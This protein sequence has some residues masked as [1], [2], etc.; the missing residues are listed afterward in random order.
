MD[1]LLRKRKSHAP[2]LERVGRTLEKMEDSEHVEAEDVIT[3][4]DNLNSIWSSYLAVHQTILDLAED[5]AAYEEVIRHQIAF[6]EEYLSLKKGLGKLQ[7]RIESTEHEVTINQQN[8]GNTSVIETLMQQQAQFLRA[9]ASNAGASTSSIPPT[10]NEVQNDIPSLPNLRLPRMNLP[11]FSG[12]FLEWQ[13]F[14]DLFSGS[15]HQNPSLRPSQ[16]LYFLKTHLA[17]EAA[18]LISHLNV[19]D[20]NYQPAL[21]KLRERYNKPREIANLHITRFLSQPH[22][23]ASSPSGLRS[24]HDVSDEVIRALAALEREGR[25]IWLMHIIYEKLDA[26]TKELWC[27]KIVEL[28]EDAVNFDA[29]LRFIDNRSSALQSSQRSRI[30]S[31]APNNKPQVSKPQPPAVPMRQK[32]CQNCLRHHSGE[33]CKAGSCRKCGLMHHTLL[34]KAFQPAAQFTSTEAPV[35]TPPQALISAINLADHLDG[36]SVL[37]LTATIDVFDK[38]GAPIPFAQCSI[39]RRISASSGKIY[40]INSALKN[41]PST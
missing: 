13:S 34:H 39:A 30:S 12:N 29:L 35:S 21:Q 25:D 26:H 22:S 17:G 36:T 40:A 18:T 23:T 19:E 1:K 28:E 7:R 9:I 3:E 33:A 38:Y 6:E 15:V 2:R 32:L 8:G 4:M 14:Y 24:L 37:L 10:N 11:I 20:A 41:P 16:K 27:Q 5:D 31:T